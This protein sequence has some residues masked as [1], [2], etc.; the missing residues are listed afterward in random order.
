MWNFREAEKLDQAKH[1]GCDQVGPQGDMLPFCSQRR[2]S[3][4]A[5]PRMFLSGQQVL[6]LCVSDC[7]HVSSSGKREAHWAGQPLIPGSRCSNESKLK[8]ELGS[9]AAGQ[10]EE[11]DYRNCPET[12]TLEGGLADAHMDQEMVTGRKVVVGAE[13]LTLVGHSAT[14][15]G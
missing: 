6:T 7:H 4:A 15:L 14:L 13:D 2:C 5:V 12:V 3:C 11:K 1:L 8:I 9:Q 10:L